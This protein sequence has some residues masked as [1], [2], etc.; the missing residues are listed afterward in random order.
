M[1]S[2]LGA[3]I[4]KLLKQ[5]YKSNN[6]DEMISPIQIGQQMI[7]WT[8]YRRVLSN[9]FYKSKTCPHA[10]L[11]IKFLKIAEKDNITT[12]KTMC[13]LLN[14]LTLNES[15][16][17]LVINEILER[18]ENLKEMTAN[19]TVKNLLS[20]F[21]YYV[22]NV[23]IKDEDEDNK[24]SIKEYKVK[25]K[26]EV[27]SPSNKDSHYIIKKDELSDDEEDGDNKDNI[28]IE[29]DNNK[30]NSEND[31]NTNEISNL[32]SNTNK[33]PKE[34][35]MDTENDENND[36]NTILNTNND[37]SNTKQNTNDNNNVDNI[38]EDVTII[39]DELL[40]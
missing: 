5:Y 4:R 38:I 10:R 29:K 18:A 40:D 8:D 17:T 3:C 39:D 16:E 7:E 14:K 33:N 22:K 12:I 37:N 30:P 34:G 1:T 19:N 25:I 20:K 26:E 6:K 15:I 13:Y 32:D 27:N 35:A 28:E 11:A 21:I 31:T 24:S 36:N 23:K 2:I 9:D